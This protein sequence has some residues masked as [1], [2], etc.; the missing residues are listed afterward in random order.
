M[1]DLD[2]GFAFNSA[3]DPAP[4][5]T[6][7]EDLNEGG[8]GTMKG[9]KGDHFGSTVSQFSKD[10]QDTVT[11]GFKEMTKAINVDDESAGGRNCDDDDDIVDKTLLCIDSISARIEKV[12]VLIDEGNKNVAWHAKRLRSSI[13]EKTL[14]TACTLLWK[15]TIITMMMMMMTERN[16]SD[17]GVNVEAYLWL[18]AFSTSHYTNF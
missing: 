3:S 16:P 2:T 1:L 14:D 5:A 10:F 15:L 11:K 18:S 9:K 4:D 8:N 7:R 13:L 17:G 12:E 6:V